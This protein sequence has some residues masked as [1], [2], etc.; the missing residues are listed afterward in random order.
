[1]LSRTY[2]KSLSNWLAPA[3]ALQ[4]SNMVW[5]FLE[6]FRW[7]INKQ[8]MIERGMVPC[9]RKDEKFVAIY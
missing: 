8:D 6:D 7:G 1:M 5:S 3:T 9:V 4:D 2:S